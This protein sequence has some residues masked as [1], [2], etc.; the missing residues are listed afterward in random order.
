MFVLCF[1]IH[2]KLSLCRCALKPDRTG[3]YPISIKLDEAHIVGSPFV[4][5]VINP[6]SPQLVRAWGPGLVGATQYKVGVFSVDV[7]KAGAG[8]LSVNIGRYQDSFNISTTTNPSTGQMD[9]SYCSPFAGS[10]SMDVLWSG[11]HIPLSPFNIT[12]S[13]TN[14]EEEDKHDIFVGKVTSGDING[15]WLKAW[16]NGTG[17]LKTKHWNQ[18]VHVD[19]GMNQTL[20]L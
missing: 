14:S 8:S 7:S 18:G 1:S 17:R 6:A 3:K 12:V 15:D 2:S 20:T 13:K 11:R 19:T 9:V 4:V 5:T 16:R 10:F